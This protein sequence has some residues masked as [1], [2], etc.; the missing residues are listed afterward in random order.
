VC[1]FIISLYLIPLYRAEN[2]QR[3]ESQNKGKGDIIENTR[4]ADSKTGL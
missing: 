4:N 2:N 3:K 1:I